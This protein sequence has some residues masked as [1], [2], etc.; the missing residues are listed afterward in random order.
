MKLLQ[1]DT[2]EQARQKLLSLPLAG[3]L[4]EERCS[5]EDSIGRILARDALAAQDLPG[6]RRST[7]DGYAVRSADTAGAGESCPA[8]LT[9]AGQVEMGRAAELTLHPGQCAYVPTG[10]EIPAG[11][12]AVV[13][14][15]YCD[16]F[17][18]GVAVCSP[19]SPGRNVVAADED[20]AAGT[21]VLPRGTRIGAREVGV[22]AALGIT[23]PTVYAPLTAA[24]LSTGDELIPPVQSPG[25]GQV[26]D[27]NTYAIAAL[28][29]QSGLR[30]VQTQLLPDAE[31]ALEAA[32]AAAMAAADL[33]L[34]SGGSSQGR[35]DRTADVIQRLAS[36]GVLTHGLAIKPGKPT[37]LGWDDP[38]RS[39]LVG[40]PGH[41]VSAFLVFRLLIGQTLQT[42]TGQPAPPALTARLTD[43][44]PAAEGK[45]TLQLVSLRDDGTGYSA[46]PIFGAS[47]LITRLTRADGYLE[48]PRDSEGLRAGSVVRVKPL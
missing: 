6:F 16:C 32:A 10:G 11:A 35:Q 37:I 24:I 14:V 43:N 33:V 29:R 26:R 3:L 25:P 34:I 13:M 12:D 42:L 38:S 1:V 30:V 20:A 44:V 45:T 39:L 17:A 19:V 41:P 28:A 5:P 21:V 40:L 9:P 2:L 8:F 7:V 27:I 36:R 23:S 31:D 48:I 18:G 46:S 4:R 22:L 15:E 47:G